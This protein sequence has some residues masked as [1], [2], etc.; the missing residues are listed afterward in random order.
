MSRSMER[1]SLL[2]D[3]LQVLCCQVL[4]LKTTAKELPQVAIRLVSRQLH[5]PVQE[6]H[7]TAAGI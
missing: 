4:I 3:G 5:T 7:A 6:W 2:W 1:F